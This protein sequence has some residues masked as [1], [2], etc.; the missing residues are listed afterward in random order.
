MTNL[1]IL[2][3]VLG[4]IMYGIIWSFKT[5]PTIKDKN[6]PQKEEIEAFYIFSIGKEKTQKF[7][8]FM[9][10]KKFARENPY[11]LCRKSNE[12]KWVAAHRKF[13]L[14]DCFVF[15]HPN[16]RDVTGYFYENRAK[17]FA[18]SHPYYKVA[19]INFEDPER[20]P[21]KWEKLGVFFNV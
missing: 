21:L 19:W 7:N 18:L 13:N 14:K 16:N 3:I 9:A 8:D 10:A 6:D 17:E 5:A 20:K 11:L 1:I 15:K 2:I 4:A 12:F